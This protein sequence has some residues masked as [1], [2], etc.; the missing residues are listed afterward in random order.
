MPRMEP[1]E[2]DD[3]IAEQNRRIIAT[4]IALAKVKN[5]RL[6]L[7]KERNEIYLAERVEEE[8]ADEL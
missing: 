6:R 2:P 8:G 7:M 1:R 4:A 5:D 3:Y